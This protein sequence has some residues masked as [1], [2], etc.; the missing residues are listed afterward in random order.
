[1]DGENLVL[2]PVEDLFGCLRRAA[3]ASSFVTFP[4]SN[5]CTYFGREAR[6]P[7]GTKKATGVIDLTDAPKNRIAGSHEK[8]P[9]AHS[10]GRKL[11]KS[12]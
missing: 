7:R 6:M 8:R 5:N 2:P 4:S 3:V 10:S 1:M 12:A 9:A 11:R